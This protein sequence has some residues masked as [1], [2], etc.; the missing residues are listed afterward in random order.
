MSALTSIQWTDRTWNP[1]RGCSVVSPGCVNCYAMKQ[2]HRFGGTPDRPGPYAGLTKQTGAGPQWTGIVR[3]ASERVLMEPYTWRKPQRI[4][5]NSM[6]D[7]FH[8]ALTNEQIA[9][10]F[11]VMH[12]EASTVAAPEH[13]Y[14]I[15]TKRPA[16]MLAWFEWLR[17]YNGDDPTILALAVYLRLQGPHSRV[18]L[19]VSCEDQKRADER[20]PLL[21]Q[22][23]AAVRFISAEPL[24]GSIRFRETL[25]G[26]WLASGLSG[27]RRGLDWVIVGGESGPGARACDRRWVYGVVDQCRQAG[28][29]CF[30]K[31]LGSRSIIDGVERTAMTDQP[32]HLRTLDRKGGDPTEWPADL[33]VRE[34]PTS[35]V[36]ALLKRKV[37]R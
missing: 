28:V 6:S 31:Q 13:T 27:E 12:G 30:V 8:E 24:I 9:E 26:D 32:A 20:I 1:V 17:E 14:Q 34:F 11:H 25:G 22:V 23:P 5:V 33:R 29:P 36:D 19:G 7:L 21:L 2:A 15:L 10:V 4:F 16:R 37:M 35:P 18:W 3:L